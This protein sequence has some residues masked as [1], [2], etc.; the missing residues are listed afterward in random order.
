MTDEQYQEIKNSYYSEYLSSLRDELKGRAVDYLQPDKSGKGFICPCEDCQ[1]GSRKGTGITT[2]DGIK[3]TCWAGCYTSADIIDIIGKAKGIVK[4]Q[5]KIQ[6][7]AKEMGI[8]FKDFREYFQEKKAGHTVTVPHAEPVKR[9]QGKYVDKAPEPDY[10]YSG[11]FMAAQKRIN[12]TEYHRGLSLKTLER[13]GVGYWPTWR[14]P[15]AQKAPASPRLIIP[16]SR[17]SFLARDTRSNLT[18]IQQQYAKSKVGRMHFFNIEACFQKE[19][20]FFIVEGEI[21]A[22]SI[23]EAGGDAVALGSVSNCLGL[24]KILADNHPEQEAIIC[25]DNDKPGQHA[26]EKLIAE[27][28]QIGVKCR[29]ADITC[30]YKDANEALNN[31]REDFIES[32]AEAKNGRGLA[33]SKDYNQITV[34]EMFSGDD[35]PEKIA[36]KI[37]VYMESMGKDSESYIKMLTEMK[38][39]CNVGIQ[40]ISSKKS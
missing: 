12:E 19:Q 5:E 22:M 11:F 17:Y 18:E 1:S 15:K 10:D 34:G 37:F 8:P 6:V 38:S 27:L 31:A 39:L 23:V 7:A 30:G 3:F 2:K 29:Q 9:F 40:T 33:P 26:A 36:R 28:Q 21:D 14:H 16:T 4:Y 35:S 25:L 13:F 32:V 24:V 20:P